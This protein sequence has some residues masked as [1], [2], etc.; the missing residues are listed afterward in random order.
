MVLASVVPAVNSCDRDCVVNRVLCG[1]GLFV[2]AY[3]S[4]IKTVVSSDSTDC[5]YVFVQKSKQLFL[6]IPPIVGKVLFHC[7]CTTPLCV[8][9]HCVAIHTGVCVCARIES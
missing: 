4:E 8:A 6:L 9:V 5:W 1:L 3:V 2:S 7:L